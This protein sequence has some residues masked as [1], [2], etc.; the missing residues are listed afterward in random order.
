M[1][2][3]ANL[4]LKTLKCVRRNDLEG[5]D[6]PV[7]NVNGH[8]EWNGVL[9]KGKSAPVNMTIQFIDLATVTLEE[10]DGSKGQQIGLPVEIP[11]DRLETRTVDFKTSGTHYTLEYTVTSA[12]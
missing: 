8:A 3:T 2:T 11:A 6:E 5:A 7:I 9:A 1:S 4:I 10:M 12:A